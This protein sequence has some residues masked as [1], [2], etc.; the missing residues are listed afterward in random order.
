MCKAVWVIKHKETDEMVFEYQTYQGNKKKAFFN[1]PKY[2][3]EVLKKYIRNPENYYI[4]F[5]M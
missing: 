2:A 5:L 3:E 4:C 1:A